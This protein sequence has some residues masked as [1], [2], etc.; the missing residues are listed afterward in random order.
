M[1]FNALVSVVIE[2]EGTYK[3]LLAEEV[4]MRKTSVSG[5][6]EDSFVDAPPK[7][8]L[9]YTPSI[10][11]SRVPPPSPHWDHHPPLQ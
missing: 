9:V 11:K 7:Y 4:K 2:Q 5:T 8:R 1:S 6:L 10:G 3:A